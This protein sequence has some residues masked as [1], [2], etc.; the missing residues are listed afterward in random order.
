M[1]Q[2]RTHVIAYDMREPH[3][4]VRV[5]RAM[6]GLGHALQYSVFAADLTPH[7]KA[8]AMNVL[9]GIIDAKVDD[10]RI[11]PVPASAFGWW[12]GPVLSPSALM[13]PTSPAATLAERLARQT[14][15]D[16]AYP[17]AGQA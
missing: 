17:H 13:Q 11:Y 7:E 16:G 1:N 5:H 12:R 8:D 14:P 9:R 15:F 4:L 2:R 10:V 3:R 6:T